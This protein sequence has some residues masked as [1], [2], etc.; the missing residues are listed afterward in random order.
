MPVQA[1]V[2]EPERALCT[3]LTITAVSVCQVHVPT[4]LGALGSDDSNTTISMHQVHGAIGTWD[5]YRRVH[6]SGTPMCL[7]VHVPTTTHL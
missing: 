2:L 5:H 6:E 7:L 4:T 3:E 1:L